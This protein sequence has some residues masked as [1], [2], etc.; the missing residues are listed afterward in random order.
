MSFYIYETTV[1]KKGDVGMDAI[2]IA[3]RYLR[4]EAGFD[5]RD[6]NGAI[7]RLIEQAERAQELK[8]K[9]LVLTIM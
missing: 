2:D 1:E 4:G 6:L 9:I 7:R 3:R 8:K 5:A